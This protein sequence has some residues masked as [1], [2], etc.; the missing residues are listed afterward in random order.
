MKDEPPL[1][2][3][4]L[5]SCVNKTYPEKHDNLC[6]IFSRKSY[7]TTLGTTV[8]LQNSTSFRL[9]PSSGYFYLWAMLKVPHD[10]SPNL[11]ITKISAQV[12]LLNS[13]KS[14]GLFITCK[15]IHQSFTLR[16][17]MARS[18]SKK[19]IALYIAVDPVYVQ[20]EA[21]LTMLRFCVATGR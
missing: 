21:S 9:P 16:V 14:I 19:Y 2:V 3:L 12:F 10:L 11:F 20:V 4:V 17:T 5:C 15:P 18:G 6:S 8:R 1:L 7:Q 13:A